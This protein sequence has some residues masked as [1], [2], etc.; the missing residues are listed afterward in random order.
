MAI[1][2]RLRS[3]P[4]WSVFGR[5][6]SEVGRWFSVWRGKVCPGDVG[7]PLRSLAK[8][9]PASLQS[10][11]E[12][13]GK[14]TER[15]FRLSASTSTQAVSLHLI[16]LSIYIYINKRKYILYIYIY[17][18]MYKCIYTYIYIYTY[19]T[20]ATPTEL[21]F[22]ASTDLWCFLH[23]NLR[24]W[25]KG[26]PQPAPFSFSNHVPCLLCSCLPFHPARQ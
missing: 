12:T 16:Y 13:A 22:H 24:I 23:G 21:C 26:S 18:Y 7:L 19:I 2:W 10:H 25:N 14:N 20:K 9:T 4:R 15:A 8:A 1:L 17:T 5:G 11:C 3:I 6:V